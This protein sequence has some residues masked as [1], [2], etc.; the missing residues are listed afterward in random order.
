MVSIL[1]DFIDKNSV[2]YTPEARIA[3][4]ER[5][6]GICSMLE[7]L[8]QLFNQNK[9]YHRIIQGFTI[10]DLIKYG[11]AEREKDIKKLKEKDAAYYRDE[12][13]I[14][15]GLLELAE[16]RQEE[17]DERRRQ[18]AYAGQEGGRRLKMYSRNYCKKR[19]HKRRAYKKN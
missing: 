17:R 12:Y 4:Q 11:K 19:S 8:I 6:K 16:E 13:Q 3:V 14:S 7:K 10:E 18:R 5:M 9:K 2:Q 15:Q 1:L